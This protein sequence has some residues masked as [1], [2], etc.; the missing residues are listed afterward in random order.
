MLID[1]RMLR[2]VVVSLVILLLI[3]AV[4][5]LG[6]MIVGGGMSGGMMTQMGAMK[7]GGMSWMVGLCLTWLTLLAGTLVFLVVLLLRGGSRR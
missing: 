6:M 1:N 3:P 7:S 4:V 5:M 2:W